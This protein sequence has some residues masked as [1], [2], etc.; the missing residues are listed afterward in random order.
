MILVVF[1]T[2]GINEKKKIII[3]KK[4]NFVTKPGWATAQVSLRLGWALGAGRAGAG[5]AGTAQATW[6][7]GRGAQE[8]WGG[9][10]AGA[11]AAG[12]GAAGAGA[13]RARWER[14]AWARGEQASA[15]LERHGMARGAR[16]QLGRRAHSR[17]Q[18]ARGHGMDAQGRAAGAGRGARGGWLGGLCAPGVRSWARLGVFLHLTQFLAWFDSVFFPS[19]QMNTVHFEI[20]VFE[21]KNIFKKKYLKIK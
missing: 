2:A 18:Q 5:R 14:Q 15:L 6:A 9:R 10:R 4:N 12:A 19:H 8:R 3:M 16:R 21:K 1:H 17:A 7:R 20:K 11:G 13:R